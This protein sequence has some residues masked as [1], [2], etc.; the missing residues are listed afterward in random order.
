MQCRHTAHVEGSTAS[1][2]LFASIDAHDV[3]IQAQDGASA[4]AGLD[5]CSRRLQQVSD[6]GH[7][8]TTVI[9][10]ALGQ[11]ISGQLCTLESAD[12]SV[13]I[14]QYLQQSSVLSML[15]KA[16]GVTDISLC[17]GS[18]L[19]GHINLSIKLTKVARANKKIN[20]WQLRFDARSG[21]QLN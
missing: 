8:H 15:R 2:E 14:R 11:L 4:S 21:L 13:T 17:Q 10:A 16:K 3:C 7:L 18:Y 1:H 19:C 5:I 12:Q 20:D 6:S 9:A